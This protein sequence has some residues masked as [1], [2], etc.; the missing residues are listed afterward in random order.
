MVTMAV[1][2]GGQRVLSRKI[3]RRAWIGAH[4]DLLTAGFF[5][6]LL[7]S[8]ALLEGLII[9][10]SLSRELVVLGAAFLAW[11]A[12]AVTGLRRHGVTW[13][14]ARLFLRT[15]GRLP[16]VIFFAL[17]IGVLAVRL[18]IG[19][20]QNAHIPFGYFA[21]FFAV[22]L[23]DLYFALMGRQDRQVRILYFLY[24]VIALACFRGMFVLAV[25]PMVAREMST[26]SFPEA[27]RHFYH[28]LG[29][30]GFEFF[31]GLSCAFPILV[32]YRMTS[33]HRRTLTVW[34]VLALLGLLFAGY[35]LAIVFVGVG[36]LLLLGYSLFH[37]RGPQLHAL[38]RTCLLLLLVIALFLG[39]GHF[40][41]LFQAHLYLLKISDMAELI[42]ERVFGVE[43]GHYNPPNLHT[44]L[45]QMSSSSVERIELYTRSIHTFLQHPLAGVGSRVNTGDFS[46]VGGHSTWLDYLAM[47]GLQ[48][49]LY[50]FFF[51]LL[52]RRLRRMIASR[53]EKAYRMTALAVYT[54]Y[55]LVNPVVAVATFPVVL[56]FFITGR[57]TLPGE[58]S[59][60]P[61]V[62]V[63]AGT[64]SAD[65][66]SA[67]TMPAVTQSPEA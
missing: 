60:T 8:P 20:G 24:A 31:T 18:A 62:Q 41:G 50:L 44:G 6:T 59:L 40:A 19:R 48:F 33:S 58:A 38:L 63:P 15:G 30:G 64:A 17:W 7:V 57:V 12:V 67:D 42:G 14:H 11:L 23:I 5:L 4:L 65:T 39:I 55:G 35:T 2:E 53:A 3:N 28:L 51:A 22:Y 34:M 25:R 66:V 32:Y 49:A 46:Q 43:L 61:S 1:A 56:L 26:G 52:F 45:S 37:L 36:L 29:V 21:F 13:R 27:Q 47:Y 10:P 16:E 9:R 54:L